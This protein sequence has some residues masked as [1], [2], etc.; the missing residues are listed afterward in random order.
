MYN[1]VILD[2]AVFKK[3]LSDR[4]LSFISG[5]TVLISPTFFRETEALSKLLDP[6]RSKVLKNNIGQILRAARNG[7][8]LVSSSLPFDVCH[9]AVGQTKRGKKVC[10]MTEDI[11]LIDRLRMSDA[12]PDIYDLNKD[13][14]GKAEPLTRCAHVE[15]RKTSAAAIPKAF[16]MQGTVLKTENG[17]SVILSNRLSEDSGHED[18]GMESSVYDV[19]GSPGLVAKIYRFYPS[20]KKHIHLK[21]LKKIAS[22]LDCPW[23]LL[24]VDLLYR[25][26]RLVGFTMKKMKVGML[27]EDTLYLGDEQAIEERRLSLKKS[28]SLDFAVTMLTQIKILN[29]YGLA[30]CDFN[31]N[32]FSAYIPKSPVVM[33][34]TDSFILDNYFGNAIDDKAFTRRYAYDDKLHLIRMAD[35]QA[36]KFCF[37]LLSLG[38]NPRVRTGYPYIFTNPASPVMYRRS[39][40][41]D[42]T[43]RFFERAFTGSDTLSVSVALYEL[44]GAR[45]ELYSHPERDLTVKQMIARACSRSVFEASAAK[46]ASAPV[47]SQPPSTVTAPGSIAA[48]AA[49]IRRTACAAP[50]PK[51]AAAVSVPSAGIRQAAPASLP[52]KD[53]SAAERITKTFRQIGGIAAIAA[54]SFLIFCLLTA[55]GILSL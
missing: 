10:V 1:M 51:P 44:T 34:D 29:C 15:H 43:A 42:S 53:A 5:K 3:P 8:K 7:A 16:C 2:A 35:E 27:S 9:E 32:N 40:F 19:C 52:S 55:S 21:K 20:V 47:R 54:L 12:P 48:K 39:Y 38:A 14:Y 45:A 30:V 41:S 33:F 6:V 13:K 28:Y 4:A 24:P 18:F 11:L 37:R 46:P 49:P 26:D 23:C 17:R 36:L 22:E 50:S 31:P 25:D